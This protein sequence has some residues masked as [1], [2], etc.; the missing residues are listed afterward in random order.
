MTQGVCMMDEETATGTSRTAVAI[1]SQPARESARYRT[2]PLSV[3]FAPTTVAVIGAT[4]TAASVGRTVLHNLVNHPFGGTVYPVNPGGSSVL[5]IRSYPSIM[6]VPGKVDLA[7]IATPADTVPDLVAQCGEAGVKG[8]IVLS[9]GFKECGEAGARLEEQIMNHAR[10]GRMRVIGPNCLG[11][12]NPVT[13]L[14]ATF[15]GAMARPGNVAFISQSGAL[16]TAVLDWS[17]REMVGFSSFV[18][19]GSMMD[20]G[21]GDLIDYF[22]DDPNTR[23]IVVYMESIGDA[24]SFLSAAREVALTKPIIV[25]KAGRHEA[26]ARAATAHTGAASGVDKVMDAAFRRCGVLR[27]NDL[28]D[29]FCMSEMLAKQPRPR[30]PRLAILT[31]AGGP[32]VLAADA[33]IDGG[34]ELAALS[35]ETMAGLDRLLPAAWSHSNPVDILGDAAPERY[36]KA[37]EI[38]AQDPQ[39]D[40]LLV[41]LTPQSMTD[42]ALTA[43]QLIPYAASVAKP[44]LASW[45]GGAEVAA[46]E[47]IL[48]KANI[49]TL[50]YPDEAARAFNYM[51]H[52]SYNLRALYETPVIIESPEQRWDSAQAENLIQTATLGPD[53]AAGRR[54]Q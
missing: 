24:R 21:W 26:A 32:G 23:S 50:P 1:D 34:G 40:G 14:N 36:G 17:L 19:I 22:G 45:M 12:M 42:P 35:A 51:W 29:L 3:F 43:E 37:I 38:I 15:A 18:S 31:N 13:G 8:V 44:L 46:G 28:L 30:G 47:R 52:Y 4:E 11:I 2:Q 53:I 10:R 49:P 20:V 9:A 7:V 16:C 54:R 39:V 6:G 48:A 5:G 33:L 27:V 41:I 25:I